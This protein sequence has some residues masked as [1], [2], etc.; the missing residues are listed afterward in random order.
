MLLQFSDP[1]KVWG[2]EL[3]ICWLPIQCAGAQ[4]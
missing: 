4:L 3:D 1:I 2:L